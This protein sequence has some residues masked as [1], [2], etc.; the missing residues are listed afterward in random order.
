MIVRAGGL[1]LRAPDTMP[2]EAREHVT[3]LQ[4]LTADALIARDDADASA[5]APHIAALE[6]VA[7][8]RRQAGR[9]RRCGQTAR[10]SASRQLVIGWGQAVRVGWA[11]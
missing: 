5:A 8:G 7:F 10:L 9:L 11:G 2:K 3:A 1:T 6:V 4:A